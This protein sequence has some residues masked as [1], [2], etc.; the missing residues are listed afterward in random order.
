[1]LSV[2][3]YSCKEDNSGQ[4]E[5]TKWQYNKKGAISITYDDGNINQFKNAVPV[6][7]SLG[8]PGNFFYCHR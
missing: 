2:L 3:F 1:M 7:D 4:T 8:L 6:M 5:I